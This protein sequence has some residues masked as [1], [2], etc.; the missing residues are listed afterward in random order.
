MGY[1]VLNLKKLCGIL[2]VHSCISFS[3]GWYSTHYGNAMC[4]YFPLFFPLHWLFPI[5]NRDAISERRCVK[6]GPTQESLWGA[7]LDSVLQ[8]IAV[9]FVCHISCVPPTSPLSPLFSGS[10]WSQSLLQGTLPQSLFLLATSTRTTLRGLKLLSS[11]EGP[12]SGKDWEPRGQDS[13]PN[14]IPYCL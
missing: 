12:S 13:G 1:S 9:M 6:G 11:L 5:W 14:L 2:C 8:V 10:P 4:F 7:P 3:F